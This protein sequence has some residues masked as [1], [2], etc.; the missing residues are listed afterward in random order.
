MKIKRSSWHYKINMLGPDTYERYPDNLC[1]YFW[2]CVFRLLF[3]AFVVLI[4]GFI[5]Y[6]YFTDPF[7]TPITIIIFFFILS[8]VLPVLAIYFL[9]KKIGGPP[10]MP[11]E[12]ILFEYLQAKKNKICPLI[13]YVD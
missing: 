8:G 10:K 11:G 2:R 6:A 13:E 4:I 3:W 9:R 5:A 12:N 7:L 1:F